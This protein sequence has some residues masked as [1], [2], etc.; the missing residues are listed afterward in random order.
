MYMY[1]CYKRFVLFIMDNIK[2]IFYMFSFIL[3]K[4][5]CHLLPYVNEGIRLKL[6]AF[7]GAHKNEL[8]F[9]QV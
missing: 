3:C 7:T 1:N 9:G 4:S 6:S 5:Y 2:Y 8:L